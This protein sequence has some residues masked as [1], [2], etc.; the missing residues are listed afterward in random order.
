MLSKSTAVLVVLAVIVTW[1]LISSIGQIDSPALQG[2]GVGNFNGGSSGQGSGSQF[3]WFSI[4]GFTIPFSMS[5]PSF[6]NIFNFNFPSFNLHLGSLNLSSSLFSPLTNSFGNLFNFLHNNQ[7]DGQSWKFPSSGSAG[8]SLQNLLQ[9]PAVLLY[10]IFAL[11]AALLI[12]GAVVSVIRRDRNKKDEKGEGSEMVLLGANDTEKD[13]GTTNF[14][15]QTADYPGWAKN[16]HFLQPEISETYPLIVGT[17]TKLEVHFPPGTLLE[18][19]TTDLVSAESERAA[20]NAKEGCNLLEGKLKNESDLLYIRGVRYKDEIIRLT[21]A[22][23]VNGSQNSLTVRELLESQAVKDRIMNPLEANQLVRMFEI[24]RY[25]KGELGV[26]NF[27]SYL[28][29]LRQSLTNPLVI[30]CNGEN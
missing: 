14:E 16:E 3:S 25:G 10:L 17:G 28:D 19:Q 9:I 24:A 20:I 7:N 12:S 11:I 2:G 5:L 18:S 29:S 1:L 13:V 26:D 30:T 15:F 23:I 6:T 21:Q 4:P 27:H 22:N 8:G